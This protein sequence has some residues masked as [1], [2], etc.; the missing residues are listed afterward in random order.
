VFV[1]ISHGLSSPDIAIYLENLEGTFADFAESKKI[2]WKGVKSVKKHTRVE[3]L[4]VMK[5]YTIT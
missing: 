5:C 4:I 1:S 2:L 3:V